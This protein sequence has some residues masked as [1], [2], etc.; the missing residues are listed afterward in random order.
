MR[1]VVARKA[2][3]TALGMT[4]TRKHGRG[5]VQPRCAMHKEGRGRRATASWLEIQIHRLGKI[6][7]GGAA[8]VGQAGH[9]MSRE[10]HGELRWRLAATVWQRIHTNTNTVRM[11]LT[12]RA[13]EVRSKRSE[14]AS[15]G[16][17]ALA[18]A[19]GV[20]SPAGSLAIKHYMSLPHS[21]LLCAIRYFTTCVAYC[22]THLR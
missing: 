12:C 13:F 10:L 20:L 19:M 8:G 14:A 5:R 17:V 15:P 4:M 9:I 7:S 1:L 2:G 22:W 11:S 3:P 6:A 21:P 18:Y 16:S